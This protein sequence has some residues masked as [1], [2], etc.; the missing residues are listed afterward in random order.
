M[1][2][3]PIYLRDRMVAHVRNI[4]AE[5]FSVQQLRKKDNAWYFDK[6]FFFLPRIKPKTSLAQT[7]PKSNEHL[8]IGRK[9]GYSLGLGC[10]CLSIASATRRR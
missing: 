1:L 2:P 4:C 10:S 5:L 3:Y 6:D 7:C 8:Q 9:N